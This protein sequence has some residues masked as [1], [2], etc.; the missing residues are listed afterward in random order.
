MDPGLRRELGYYYGSGAA[1]INCPQP[2]IG[3]GPAGAQGLAIA[4]FANAARRAAPAVIVM[5]QRAAGI[6]Q[7]RRRQQQV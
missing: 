2:L 3:R 6:A 5:L 4:E 1:R 7:D